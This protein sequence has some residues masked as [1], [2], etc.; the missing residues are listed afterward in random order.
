[1]MFTFR[2]AWTAVH[3]TM[4]GFG[5]IMFYTGALALLFTLRSRLLTPEGVQRNV[6]LLKTATAIVAVLSWVAVF[7]GTYVSYPWYRAAPPAGTTELTMYARS[8]LLANAGKEAWHTFGMEWK[9]HVAWIS[10]ILA[11]AAAAVVWRYGRGL[12]DS[13]VLNWTVVVTTLVSFAAA[14]VA[15]VLGAFIT[16]TAPVI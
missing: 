16:K 9:E 5:F 1:M 7:I 6:A 15:G 2:E 10:P 11:T 4:M 14:A 12:K 8:F 3:G 13:L